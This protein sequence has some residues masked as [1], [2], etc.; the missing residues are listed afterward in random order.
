MAKKY[1]LDQDHSCHWYVIDADCRHDWN[2]WL[3]LDEDD[4]RAWQAPNFAKEL[5]TGPS[6]IEF[7]NYEVYQR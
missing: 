5:G 2:E 4:E 1:F 6:L 3:D 7:S